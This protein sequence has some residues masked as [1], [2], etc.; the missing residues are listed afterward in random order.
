MKNKDNKLF[1][2]ISDDEVRD[3]LLLQGDAIQTLID[4]VDILEEDLIDLKEQ[5]SKLEQLI[6]ERNKLN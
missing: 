6:K 4:T 3:M 2:D 5:F 1:K